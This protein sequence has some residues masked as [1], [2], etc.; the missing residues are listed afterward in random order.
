MAEHAADRAGGMQGWQREIALA[1]GSLAFGLILLPFAIYVVGRQL[2]GEYAGDGP[3]ALAESIWLDLATLRPF[4]W[5]LVLW[6]YLTVQ[7]VRLVRRV[8]RRQS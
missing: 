1:A 2:V 6:P 4:T 3:L 7:L 5:L 8:W